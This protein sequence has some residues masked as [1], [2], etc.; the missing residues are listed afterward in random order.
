MD[1]ENNHNLFINDTDDASENNNLD[2]IFISSETSNNNLPIVKPNLKSNL[3]AATPNAITSTNAITNVNIM[4]HQM[5]H[6]NLNNE[7]VDVNT[8]NNPQSPCSSNLPNTVIINN[9][10]KSESDINGWDEDATT[11]IKNWYNIF[12]QQSFIYQWILD[13]NKKISNKLTIISILASSLLGI[14]TGFKLWIQN[15]QLFQTISNIL[16]MLFNF[17]VAL[18]TACS[19]S[20]IDD[21]RNEKLRVYIEEVDSFLGEISAQVLKSPVYR[22]NADKFFKLSNDK[23]TR[24]ISC[25][26]NLSIYE[27]KQGKYEYN[28]YYS[29]CEKHV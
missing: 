14:F 10:L 5:H 12:K 20:Y 8:S 17:I 7:L 25:A 1:K 23:Y 15:D 3:D 29:H 16:L 13:R 2:H 27:I 6:H 4:P 26:P 11:T 24:L 9:M 21:K 28:L 18:I 19:R 22:M